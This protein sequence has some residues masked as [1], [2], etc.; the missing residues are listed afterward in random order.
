[1]DGI[2]V[3]YDQNKTNIEQTLNEFKKLQPTIKFIIEKE[4]H[5]S[6]SFL[7]LTIHREEGKFLFS[8]YRKPTQTGIIIPNDSCHP[9]EHKTSSIKTQQSAQLPNNKGRKRNGIKHHQK[10]TT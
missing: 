10:H 1:V 9:H 4:L 8:I 3:I 2:L 5:E 7:D 6:I